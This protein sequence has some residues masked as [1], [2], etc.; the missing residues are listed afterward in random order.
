MYQFESLLANISMTNVERRD[1][2]ADYHK[3]GLDALQNMT[4]SIDFAGFLAA[5]GVNTTTFDRNQTNIQSLKFYGG[6]DA[7]LAATP[8]AA[9]RDFLAWRYVRS[10]WTEKIFDLLLDDTHFASTA[11]WLACAS[12]ASAPMR[13]CCQRRF[14]TFRLPLSKC[15]TSREQSY[16]F[17]VA[18]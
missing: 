12:V 9:L 7:V 17:F 18:N 16:F 10:V 14:A 2:N 13:R 6:L 11:F 3:L 4:Q 8:P 1:P 5:V 15:A